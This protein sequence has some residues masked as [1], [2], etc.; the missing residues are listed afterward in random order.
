MYKVIFAI[1]RAVIL[2]NVRSSYNSSTSL[3]VSDETLFKILFG[4]LIFFQA[5]DKENNYVTIIHRY[6]HIDFKTIV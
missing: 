1:K 2:T 4:E 3:L 6:R 5:R